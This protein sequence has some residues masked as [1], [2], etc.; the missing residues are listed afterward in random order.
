MFPCF[1]QKRIPGW[2]RFASYV[3]LGNAAALNYIHAEQ[4]FATLAA[5]GCEVHVMP[6]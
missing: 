4:V 3:R 6:C 5:V 2:D 1:V